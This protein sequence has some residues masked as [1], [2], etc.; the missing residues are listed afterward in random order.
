[1]GGGNDISVVTADAG[2]MYSTM[3]A[4]A[5]FAAGTGAMYSTTSAGA[6]QDTACLGAQVQR[7]VLVQPR[8]RSQLELWR[9]QTARPPLQEVQL[10]GQNTCFT[11]S[12]LCALNRHQK[13]DTRS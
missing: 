4:G 7:T 5:A 8:S 3:G 13:M 1:M 9:W 10:E 11:V 2:A 6:A 12:Q